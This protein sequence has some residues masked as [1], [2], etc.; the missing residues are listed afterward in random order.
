MEGLAKSLSCPLIDVRRDFLLSHQFG[1]L[2][3]DD[4]IHPTPAGHDLIAGHITSYMQSA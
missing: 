4:G 1:S 2:L 3:C